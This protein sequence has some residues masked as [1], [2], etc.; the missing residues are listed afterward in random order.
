MRVLH[1]KQGNERTFLMVDAA[2]ND[3][4]RPSLYDA[5]HD[6]VRV[7]AARTADAVYDIVGPVCETGDTFAVAR[8][9]PRCEAGDLLA[10][11]ATGA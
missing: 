11:L 9:L 8:E 6:I 4:L 5:W 10:I 7:G 1:A 3:L 2:M